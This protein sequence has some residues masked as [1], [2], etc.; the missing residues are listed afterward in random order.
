MAHHSHLRQQPQVTIKEKTVRN[1]DFLKRYAEPLLMTALTAAVNMALPA[2]GLIAR[3]ITQSSVLGATQ[4]VQETVTAEE[5]KNK[6]VRKI[7]TDPLKAITEDLIK[8]AIEANK[9]DPTITIA[10]GTRIT[11]FPSKDLKLSRVPSKQE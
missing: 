2:E 6:E 5:E 7:L 10:A 4:T 11:I 3:Q 8:K 9:K 1:P